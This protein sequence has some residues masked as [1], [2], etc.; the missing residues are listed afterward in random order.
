[1]AQISIRKLTQPV[2]FKIK[3]KPQTNVKKKEE[4]EAK[5]RLE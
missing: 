4:N 1:M 2:L 3:M 5:Y